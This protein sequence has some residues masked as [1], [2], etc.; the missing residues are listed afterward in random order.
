MLKYKNVC[1]LGS[2]HIALESVNQVE[3]L[4]S[5]IKPKIVALELDSKR[6]R[7]LLSEKKQKTSI[8][9]I[10]KIGLK[11]YF[12][13]LIGSYIEK[14]LGKLSGVSPGSEMKKAFQLAHENNIKIALIDQDIDIT[15]AKLSKR[16]TWKEKI[17]FVFETI[18]SLFFKTKADFDLKKVPHKKIIKEL[19]EE[20]RKKYP[21]FYLTLV[22]ERNEFMAKALYNLMLHN[23]GKI[24]AI[25]GAG[26]EDS[27]VELLKCYSIKQKSNTL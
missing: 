21:S 14:S 15:L 4:I 24:L 16:M 22:V 5:K 20:F 13:N 17:N 23:K 6:L 19:T 18:L 10:R 9:D 25:V 2:S 3:A 8:K 1:L 27:I 26:H 7:A 11:G 12:F